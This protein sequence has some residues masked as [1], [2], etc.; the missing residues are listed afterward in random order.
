M[1]NVLA[2]VQPEA[3]ELATLAREHLDELVTYATHLVGNTDDAMEFVAGGIHHASRYPPARLSA[4]GRAALFRAVTRA[5]K[6]GQRYPPRPH[7]VGRLFQRSR[8]AFHAEIDTG[9]AERMN[10][11]K[12]ALAMLSFER[13][14][15]LLLRDLAELDYREMSRVLECSPESTARLVAAAR[16]E[17][18]SIYREIAL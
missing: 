7:G 4:D 6:H 8:P 11:V 18:G 16:R 2:N 13:R 1:I 10:T 5:I 9:G 17:F 12:R 15:S 14:A 3:H